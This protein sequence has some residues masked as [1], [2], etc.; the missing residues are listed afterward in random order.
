MHIGAGD[1]E[2]VCNNLHHIARIEPLFRLNAMQNWQKWPFLRCVA[3]KDS[4]HNFDGFCVG[5]VASPL[6]APLVMVFARLI[7]IGIQFIDRQNL[8]RAVKFGKRPC[9]VQKIRKNGGKRFAVWRHDAKNMAGVRINQRHR[10]QIV[11]LQNNFSH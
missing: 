5:H 1:I 2:A 10:P 6:R 9:A 11:A 7:S 8:S 3:G 4:S